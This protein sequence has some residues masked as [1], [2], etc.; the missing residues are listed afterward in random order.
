MPISQLK[1][2]E[3]CQPSDFQAQSGRILANG[4]RVPGKTKLGYRLPGA[5]Q[6]PRNEG[7]YQ[8]SYEPALSVVSKQSLSLVRVVKGEW[9]L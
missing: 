9:T 4:S 2:S 1:K 3:R 5:H 6:I 8:R 7:M